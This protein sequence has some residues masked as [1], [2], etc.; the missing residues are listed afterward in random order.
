[1]KESTR[2]KGRS[3]QEQESKMKLKRGGYKKKQKDRSN[4]CE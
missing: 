4:V 3:V 2:R 1:M